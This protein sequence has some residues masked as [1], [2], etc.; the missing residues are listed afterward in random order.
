MCSVSI[1]S[2]AAMFDASSEHEY[3]ALS[4]QSPLAFEAQ[5]DQL[6]CG[7]MGIS[8]SRKSVSLLIQ[9]VH[10]CY[11]SGVPTCISSLQSLFSITI[12]SEPNFFK[13]ITKVCPSAKSKSQF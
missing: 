8:E 2:E 12:M 3:T 13:T 11:V 9:R 7:L 1:A 4:L 6:G 5:R 10:Q